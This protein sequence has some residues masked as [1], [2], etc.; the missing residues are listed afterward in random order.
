MIKPY[1]INSLTNIAH[2]CIPKKKNHKFKY[3][4]HCLELVYIIT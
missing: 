3:H 2:N 4:K 1:S